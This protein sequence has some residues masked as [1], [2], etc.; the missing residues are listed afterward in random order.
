[1]ASWPNGKASDYDQNSTKRV[2]TKS[3]DSGFDPQRGHQRY[4]SYSLFLNVFPLYFLGRISSGYY[5]TVFR[6][7]IVINV[8]DKDSLWV[9]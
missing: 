9:K 6:D 4:M 5:K 1:M 7:E 2:Q 3:G 8:V